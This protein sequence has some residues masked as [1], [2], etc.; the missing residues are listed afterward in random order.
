MQKRKLQVRE[1]EVHG[2]R[3]QVIR[4]PHARVW[5]TLA[6]G[7][8]DAPKPG[9]LFA[10]ESGERRFL[11]MTPDDFLSKAE[12]TNLTRIELVELLQRAGSA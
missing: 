9:L 11:P 6:H 2:K 4:Q 7:Q 10:C 12:F 1:F 5:T 3:W 8:D